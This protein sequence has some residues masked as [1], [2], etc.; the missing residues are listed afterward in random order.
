MLPKLKPGEVQRL[1]RWLDDMPEAIAGHARA[2]A[3]KRGLHGTLG[4]LIDVLEFAA[5]R[6]DRVALHLVMEDVARRISFRGPGEPRADL[7]SMTPGDCLQ[8]F[9]RNLVSILGKDY[10]LA[11]TPGYEAIKRRSLFF[12]SRTDKSERARPDYAAVTRGDVPWD[13]LPN[14]GAK[15]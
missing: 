15:V 2:L 4:R 10:Q 12:K 1:L 3:A 5:G 14:K 8:R 9:L 13:N 6:M 7:A 11:D